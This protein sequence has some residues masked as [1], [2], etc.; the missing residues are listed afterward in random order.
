MSIE[1]NIANQLLGKSAF[2]ETDVKDWESLTQQY[3]YFSLAQLLLTKKMLASNNAN[4][5]KQARKTALHFSYIPQLDI[6]LY[7]GPFSKELF[8]GAIAEAK[9]PPKPISI[10]TEELQNERL[11]SMLGQQL[12][13]FKKTIDSN[14]KLLI[15]TEPLFK[16]DY[17][18]SQGIIFTKQQDA[19]GAKVKKFTD[20]LKDIK[21]TTSGEPQLNTTPEE[22]KRAAAQAIASLESE[23]TITE[24][25]AEVLLQQNKK[26]HAIEIY[27]KL[28]LLY[29]EKSTYFASKINLLQR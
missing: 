1:N 11:S 17:F 8:A 28:S 24:S 29:P 7:N 25:M 6:L 16:T 21:K 20:W 19:L 14:E 3:P 22:E 2:A 18:A 15:E 23:E 13:A 5:A 26:E 27:K 4:F 9:V 10:A 12:A